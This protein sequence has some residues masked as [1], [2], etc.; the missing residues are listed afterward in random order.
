MSLA[1]MKITFGMA[2]FMVNVCMVLVIITIPAVVVTPV[3]AT[4]MYGF[5]SMPPAMVPVVFARMTNFAEI[6]APIMRS[7]TV[8]VLDTHSTRLPYET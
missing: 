8:V 4:V 3:P 1:V 7:I 6:T 2:L 5:T